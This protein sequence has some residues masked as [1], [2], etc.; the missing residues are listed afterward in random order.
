MAFVER[1]TKSNLQKVSFD[2]SKET[3]VGQPIWITQGSRYLA[4]PNLSPD[5]EWIAF[6]SAGVTQE[7]IFL[8]RTNGT[9][10]RQITNG[11]AQ[12]RVPRW[13]PD[14]KRIIFFSN[15]VTDRWQIW[16]I[17]PDGSGLRRL[18]ETDQ[19]T[20]SPVWSQDSTRVAYNCMVGD[21]FENFISEL[22][23]SWKDHSE[24]LPAFSESEFFS[25]I[26]WSPDGKWLGGNLFRKSIAPN[27]GAF[28]SSGAAVYSLENKRF[29]RLA[30]FGGAPAWLGDSRR[31]LLGYK[32]K[33][34]I[35]DR[36]SMKIRE[37]FDVRPY[38]IWSY[39]TVSKD[40]RVICYALEMNEADIWL[41]TLQ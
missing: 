28:N 38:T 25:V 36:G 9:G 20:S 7:H 8:I 14:G 27:N 18:G 4:A 11:P 24:R 37:I 10:E 12:D 3:V 41:M 5:G 32:D 1:I 39:L 6:C 30:D 13:S 34:Y 29:E 21:H 16:A 35:A 15:R 26:T 19:S 17:N 22:G 23:K 40:N 33:I 2:P 31:L